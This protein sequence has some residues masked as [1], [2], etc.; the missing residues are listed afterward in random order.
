MH[1]HDHGIAWTDPVPVSDKRAFWRA[2]GFSRFAVGR[3]RGVMIIAYPV[4]SLAALALAIALGAAP[5]GAAL[6][7]A[8]GTE[9]MT[10]QGR[11]EAI[12]HGHVASQLNGLVAEILFS[13]GERVAAGDPLIIMD[14]RDADLLVAEA[15]AAQLSAAARLDLAERDADRV[16]RLADRGAASQASRD[17]ADAALATARADVAQA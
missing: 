6:A 10:F 3:S 12:R 1:G 5:G 13:G 14:S 16:A 17:N 8:D 11:V 9:T 15:E 7:Q 2:L 4:R